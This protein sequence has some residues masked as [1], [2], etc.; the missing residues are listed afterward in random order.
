MQ[1]TR[2]K[3]ALS[4][5]QPSGADS[6]CRKSTDSAQASAPGENSGKS[7]PPRQGESW[8]EVRLSLEAPPLQ[9]R[10]G[11]ASRDANQDGD[12][13]PRAGPSIYVQTCSVHTGPEE[14]LEGAKGGLKKVQSPQLEVMNTSSIRT[15]SCL[16][17]R[18]PSL[19]PGTPEPISPRWAAGMLGLARLAAS[20]QVLARGRSA[21]LKSA[22]GLERAPQGRGFQ[23]ASVWWGHAREHEVGQGRQAA[24]RAGRKASPSGGRRMVTAPSALGAGARWGSARLGSQC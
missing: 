1:K 22:V 18:S 9:T 14:L 13:W 20:A 8:V 16:L 2:N 6:A 3:G 15:N 17:S 7:Q 4:S 23:S 11:W 5:F 19:H 24:H 21:A 10:T 12:L